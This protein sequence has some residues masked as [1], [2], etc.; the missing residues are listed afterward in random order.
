MC[1]KCVVFC[2]LA[3]ESFRSDALHMTCSMLLIKHCCM[4]RLDEYSS[5]VPLFDKPL[6]NVDTLDNEIP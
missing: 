2:F 1:T 4:Q 5:R 6:N 3:K